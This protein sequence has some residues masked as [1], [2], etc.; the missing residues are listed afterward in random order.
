MGKFKNAWLQ[1]VRHTGPVVRQYDTQG[2]RGGVTVRHGGPVV[3]QHD[4]QGQWYGG[5]THRAGGS[6]VRH[7]GSRHACIMYV[8]KMSNIPISHSVYSFHFYN[9]QA[10]E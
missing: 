4:T 3:R 1:A 6:A 9:M 5:T 7:G 8:C 10:Y 2:R